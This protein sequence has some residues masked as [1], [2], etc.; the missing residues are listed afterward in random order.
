MKK[1]VDGMVPERGY[2]LRKAFEKLNAKLSNML[3][4]IYVK[5]K[6]FHLKPNQCK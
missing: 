1:S 5:G 6:N 4:K 2:Q 3:H